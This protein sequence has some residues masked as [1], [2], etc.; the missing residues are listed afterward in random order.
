ML[1][2]SQNYAGIRVPVL[3][4]YQAQRPFEEVAVAFV[5]RNEQERAALRRQYA[6]TRAM[7]TRWQHD[8]LAGIPSARIVELP[9]A[10]LFMFLSNQADVPSLLDC[11][12]LHRWPNKGARLGHVHRHRGAR[13]RPWLFRREADDAVSD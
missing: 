13:R 12:L 4:I 6:A 7:Y 2:L 10:Y 8:P 11:M 1:G 3:A 5:I 9:G